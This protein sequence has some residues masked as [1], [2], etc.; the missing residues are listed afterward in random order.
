[1]TGL[2]SLDLP[3]WLSAINRVSIIRYGMRLVARNEFKHITLQPCNS[4]VSDGPCS[5]QSGVQVLQMY[6][7]DAATDVEDFI[8]LVFLTLAYRVCAYFTLR[9]AAGRTRFAG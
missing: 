7:L 4:Q 6:R 1:M 8:C 2:M 9:W 5:F 3:A